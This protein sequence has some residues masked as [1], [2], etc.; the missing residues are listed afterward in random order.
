MQGKGERSPGGVSSV[1]DQHGW[2]CVL[3]KNVFG[4]SILMGGWRFTCWL[5]CDFF[6]VVALG[7][8][9]AGCN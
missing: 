1:S 8:G 4:M 5:W 3:V 2:E 9:A 7:W 6:V